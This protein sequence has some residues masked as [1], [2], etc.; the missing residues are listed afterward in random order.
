[1]RLPS[2]RCWIKLQAE[3]V[4]RKIYKDDEDDISGG[5]TP[6]NLQEILHIFVISFLQSVLLFVFLSYMYSCVDLMLTGWLTVYCDSCRFFVYTVAY[7][8]RSTIWIKYDRWI[9]CKRFHMK[10]QCVTFFGRIRTIVAVGEFL[11]EVLVIH[12]ART[13]PSSSTITMGYL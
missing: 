3:K 2:A 10:A 1:M 11:Q 7:R 5:E 9:V 8:H 12:L 6:G 13:S 4:G